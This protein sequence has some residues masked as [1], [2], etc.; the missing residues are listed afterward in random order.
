[1]V[2][3]THKGKYDKQGNIATRKECIAL[4]TVNSFDDSNGIAWCNASVLSNF[5]YSPAL[6]PLCTFYIFLYIGIVSRLY[7]CVENKGQ[8]QMLFFN[9]YHS[10][11]CI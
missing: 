10:R 2:S 5:I 9:L 3:D 11:N 1:M 6:F 4:S 7:G 8:T